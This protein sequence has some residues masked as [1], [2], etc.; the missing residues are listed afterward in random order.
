MFLIITSV[1]YICNISVFPEVCCKI[2]LYFSTFQA[3]RVDLGAMFIDGDNDNPVAKLAKDFDLP[4]QNFDFGNSTT[5]R[6]NPEEEVPE[7]E[8]NDKFTEVLE[9]GNM[10]P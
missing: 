6:E 4:F 7:Q 3:T 5:R 2:P 9:V 10:F 1:V 8:I